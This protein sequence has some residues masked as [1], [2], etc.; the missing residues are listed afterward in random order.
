[1]GLTTD[2][3]DPGIRKIQPDGQQE[4][5]LV[6]SEE[7]RAKGFVRPV[8]YSYRHVGCPSAGETREL[9]TE[10]HERYDTLWRRILRAIRSAAWRDRRKILNSG[11]Q[12]V[13]MMGQAIAETYARNPKF[14]GKTF[15]S[16]CGQ[17]FPIGP[18][19]EFVWEPD[20]SRVGT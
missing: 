12:Q 13:T 14:Y 10:E 4:V 1:M 7:E 3:N 16:T 9:T 8:R 11:C 6:L 5:Y 19:G 15:C 18:D 20:G 2:R 17:H